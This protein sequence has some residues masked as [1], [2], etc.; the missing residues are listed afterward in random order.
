M[1]HHQAGHDASSVRDRPLLFVHIRKT[2][3]LSFRHLL[4]SRFAA[5]ACLFDAHAVDRQ[6]VDPDAY[7]FVH[8]HV[9]V[10][11]VERFRR[12]PVVFTVLRHPID[13]ALSAY[14]FFR[15]NGP[16]QL[17]QLRRDLPRELFA[18]RVWFNRRARE[19]SLLE[20]LE[21]EPALVRAHLGDVQT[22]HLAGRGDGAE[23]DAGSLADARR[24]LAS[25][26]VVG[27]TER[28][29]DTLAL[30]SHEFGWGALG[31]LPHDNPTRGRPSIAE[32]DPRA[33]DL[34]AR[35]NR[36]DAE[37]YAHARDLLAE[38]LGRVE[39]EA[40][41]PAS[42]AGCHPTSRLPDVTDFTFDQPIHGYG[43]HPRERHAG[44]WICWTG[45]ASEAW[46]DLRVP[47]RGRHTLHCR[48]SHVL[49]PSVLDGLRVS[50]NGY[51]L[52]IRMRA[53][54]ATVGVEA[55]VP[56]EALPDGDGRA[57]I[58][59]SVTET[60]RPCDLDPRADDRR[61]LGIALSRI[62]VQPAG[63]AAGA[64]TPR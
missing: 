30:L 35:A 20:F 16:R 18:S 24:H 1:G 27:L 33:L 9:D 19:L 29:D 7:A 55:P 49:R 11:Y 22:R 53:A 59:F 61:Q 36:R 56:P 52:A 25:C 41:A 58:R 26:N 17:E 54:E 63:A 44:T 37:L 10:R 46:I 28:P 6:S 40:L 42:A 32:V 60:H 14:Y 51:P 4:A 5:A 39:P 47:G 31:P 13:R 23:L 57:R 48:V 62:R 34:L 38:R 50:V 64:S 3:G 2:A 15:D 12:R 8:G 21:R 45:A 43:W